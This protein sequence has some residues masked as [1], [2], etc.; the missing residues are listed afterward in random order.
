MCDIGN[1]LKFLRKGRGLTQLQLS[2]KLDISRCTISN[3]ECSRRS[4]HLS[5]LS[6]FAEFYGVSLS[7]F[8]I[9]TKDER[10]E[11]L[12]RAK[13]VFCNDD[14]SKEEKEE[15]YKSIMKIY[16]QL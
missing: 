9:D 6:R 10:F 12:S 8:G 1:K 5:D 4:P 13:S 7:Y 14:I 16:L 3:Y 2:E 11:L 15:I